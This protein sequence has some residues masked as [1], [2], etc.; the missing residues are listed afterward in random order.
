[1]HLEV[2][3]VFEKLL[4]NVSFNSFDALATK[5]LHAR[6][7]IATLSR[8]TGTYLLEDIGVVVRKTTQKDVPVKS[9]VVNNC[10]NQV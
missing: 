5:A 3:T 7:G 8:Q 2:Y 10:G 9:R 1:L 6:I 4:T